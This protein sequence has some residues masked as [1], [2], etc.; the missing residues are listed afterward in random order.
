MII[1]SG[2]YYMC[3]VCG[4]MFEGEDGFD[5]CPDCMSDDIDIPTDEEAEEFLENNF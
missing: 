5:Y 3:L 4:L 2:M 1:E